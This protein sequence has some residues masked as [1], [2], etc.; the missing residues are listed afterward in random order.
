M[1]LGKILLFGWV[2]RQII[3]LDSTLGMRHDEFPLAVTDGETSAGR[4]MNHGQA[5]I[6]RFRPS[7]SM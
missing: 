7:K 3:E 2:S 5:A 6:P 4:M 1:G